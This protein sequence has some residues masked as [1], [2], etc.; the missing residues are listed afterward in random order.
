MYLENYVPNFIRIAQ[1]LQE[2][3]QKHY[4]RFFPDIMYNEHIEHRNEPKNSTT[5]LSVQNMTIKHL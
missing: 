3:L 4:A 2:I 1:V 5:E